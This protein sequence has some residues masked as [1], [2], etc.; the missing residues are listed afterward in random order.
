MIMQNLFY[1]AMLFSLYKHGG[2][3]ENLVIMPTD[4]A[5]QCKTILLCDGIFTVLNAQMRKMVIMLTEITCQCKIC[6]SMP[7]NFLCMKKEKK[8][9]I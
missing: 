9:K 5:C 4:I 2:N 3:A 1:N 8:Q 7:W 6:S